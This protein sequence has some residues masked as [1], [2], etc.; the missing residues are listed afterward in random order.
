MDDIRKWLGDNK[1]RSVGKTASR[2]ECLLPIHSCSKAS[3][4][5]LITALTGMVLTSFCAG[6]FWLGSCGGILSYQLTRPIPTSV[7]IMHTRVYAQVGSCTF[8]PSSSLKE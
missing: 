5:V 2:H 1:L 4:L 7:A 6:L 3:P 8:M